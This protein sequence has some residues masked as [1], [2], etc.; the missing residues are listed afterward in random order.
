MNHQPNTRKALKLATTFQLEQ[1]SCPGIYLPNRTSDIF[2]NVIILNKKYRSPPL[3]STFPMKISEQFHVEKIFKNVTD[4]FELG[5]SLNTEKVII[6]LI[7]DSKPLAEVAVSLKDFLYNSSHKQGSNLVREILIHKN[8]RFP[9]LLSPKLE[10]ISQTSIREVIAKPKNNSLHKLYLGKAKSPDQMQKIKEFKKVEKIITKPAK[11]EQPTIEKPPWNSPKKSLKSSIKTRIQK[12]SRTKIPIEF[13]SNPAIM[14]TRKKSLV[15]NM[16]LP[17][18]MRSTTA[19]RCKSPTR[20]VKNSNQE[21]TT[22]IKTGARINKL[23][24]KVKTTTSLP[25]NLNEYHR[26]YPNKSFNTLDQYQKFYSEPSYVE[27][28]LQNEKT[29]AIYQQAL[30]DQ[31]LIEDRL[32][33]LRVNFDKHGDYYWSNNGAFMS[34]KTH[35]QTF[36]SLLDEAYNS[37]YDTLNGIKAV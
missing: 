16:D 24:E 33:N 8:G 4:P 36:N 7:Q 19:S 31:A 12:S 37:F 1:I 35:R 11:I 23:T 20:L 3:I 28:L 29:R 14:V 15:S 6:S 10:F 27:K 22:P 5:E 13:N 25:T 21:L 2:L 34:G 32:N 9:G 17:N 18:Y 26:K 30:Q